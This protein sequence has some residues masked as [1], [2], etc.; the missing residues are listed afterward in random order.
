[1]RGATWRRETT[2]PDVHFLEPAARPGPVQTTVDVRGLSPSRWHPKLVRQGACSEAQA[3][4]ARSHDFEQE[5][6]K[7]F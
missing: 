4:D 1:M 2:C 5:R 6:F 7:I 3:P